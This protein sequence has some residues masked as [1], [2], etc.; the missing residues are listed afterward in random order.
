MTHQQIRWFFTILYFYKTPNKFFF[1][2]KETIKE[3]SNEAVSIR[4]R[5]QHRDNRSFI[6]VKQKTSFPSELSVIKIFLVFG[7]VQWLGAFP[8]IPQLSSRRHTLSAVRLCLYVKKYWRSCV[9]GRTLSSIRVI[10]VQWFSRKVIFFMVPYIP[11]FDL[12]HSTVLGYTS[13]SFGT[14]VNRII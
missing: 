3:Y 7:P 11:N 1:S 12:Y 2:D 9:V 5:L 6:F 14:R 4:M 10:A 8:R 13:Y